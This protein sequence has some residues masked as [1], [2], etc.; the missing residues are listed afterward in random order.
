MTHT[1]AKITAIG[2]ALAAALVTGA[3]FAG[4]PGCASKAEVSASAGDSPLRPAS[5]V[6]TGSPQTAGFIKVGGS[7]GAQNYTDQGMAKGHAKK[8]GTHGDIVDTAAA[9]GK[10]TTLITAVKTAGLVDTLKGDGPF[11]VFAPTDEAFA[12]LP[13]DQLDALLNDKEALTKILTYHVVAGKVMSTDVVNLNSAKTV[14]GQ[15]I[16]IN[17]SNGVRVNNANVIM[18]DI[19]TSNGVIH[20]LDTVILPPDM[21]ASL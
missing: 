17:A 4:G 2:T 1:S 12:K 20:V 8:A 7:M 18:T 10:F 6:T 19:E 5:L 11:T 9:N 14:E 3:A 15:A 21:T 16:T 13:K